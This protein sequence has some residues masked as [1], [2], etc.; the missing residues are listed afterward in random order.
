[1]K[2]WSRFFFVAGLFNILGGIVGFL[3]LEDQLASMGRPAPLYPFAFELLFLAVAILGVGYL[4]VAR[5]PLRHR[6]IVWIGLLTKI[7]GGLMSWRAI[8]TGQMPAE[9]WWQAVVTDWV[10]V[11][12]FMVFLW[13]TRHGAGRS[14]SLKT[15]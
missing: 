12:A 8:A 5:D 11:V 10:W 3:T 6:G 15:S 9:T 14:V 4:M 2:A 7:A 1:M 13:T